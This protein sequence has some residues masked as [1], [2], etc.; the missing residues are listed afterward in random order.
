MTAVELTPD[1]L[2]PFA[3]IDGAK[4]Q[5]MIDDALALAA[6]VAPCITDDDFAY[7]DAAK[8]IL[9]GAVLRWNEAGTG[10]LSNEVAG[11]FGG[12]VDNRQPRRS[13]FWP[14]EI[15]ELQAMCR[16]EETSGA[17][18]V[19]TAPCL[20]I[21]SPVCALYFGATYCSCAADIAGFPLYEDV[22]P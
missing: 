10:A 21:H 13:L 18:S 1:D 22:E 20:T 6:R 2:V 17:F 12:T 7:P 4:A 5:A 15:E 3:D 19:D 9:R 14:S 8:A 16:G 11:P